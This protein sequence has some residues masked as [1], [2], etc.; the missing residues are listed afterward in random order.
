M[1][2]VPAKNI[3]RGPQIIMVGGETRT[4]EE[5]QSTTLPMDIAVR[6]ATSPL[7]RADW[8][9]NFSGAKLKNFKDDL[10]LT[11]SS[12]MNSTSGYGRQ[13]YGI[14]KNLAQ[15]FDVHFYQVSGYASPNMA[16]IDAETRA[17]VEREDREVTEWGICHSVIEALPSMPT[18]KT[19]AWSMWE[20]DRLPDHRRA[21][22]YSNW[23]EKINNHAKALIVPASEQARIFGESG[24]K[25]PIHIVHDAV[26]VSK[27]RYKP[28]RKP[29]DRPF[30]FFT[31]AFMNS[32]KA[33]METLNSFL[34][35]F[36]PNNP[37]VRIVI[38]TIAHQFG[39]GLA[40]AIPKHN[41]SNVHI[42]DEHWPEDYLLG[43]LYNEVDACFFLSKG[44]GF[45]DPPLEALSTGLPVIVPDHSG[46]HDYCDDRYVY[47]IRTHHMERSLQADYM[48]WWIPDYDQGIS[49]LREVYNNYDEAIEKARKGAEWVSTR[50]STEHQRED[51]KKV[52]EKVCND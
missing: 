12:S 24:V 38:K 51:L 4:V 3:G 23:A 1:Q 18:P 13:G 48:D 42:I 30:T 2:L 39:G 36:G 15:D 11:Y 22:P 31:W 16:E 27:W 45:Y 6:W 34:S 50:W 28:R 7:Y 40:G 20:A 52:L 25:V 37:D 35:A 10:A 14:F 47:P 49:H 33:P 8:E 46:P 32:R 5:G 41:F 29:I 19:I 9:F 21:G 26:D 17:L 44:E 43:Y